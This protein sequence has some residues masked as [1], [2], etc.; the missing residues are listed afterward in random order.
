VTFGS[1]SKR[2]RGTFKARVA[3]FWRW[4][5]DVAK[6]FEA[7]AE[8]DDP[9]EVVNEVGEYMERTLPGLSWALGRGEN[10]KHS[11]TVTGEG[12]VPKQLLAAYWQSQAVELPGWTFYASR[13]PSPPET[14]KDL[15]IG[16]SEDDQVDA[17]SV[18]VKTSVDEEAEQI[19]IIAWH[20]SLAKVPAEHHFQI[21]FLLLDEALG[22]FGVQTWLGEI[23]VEPIEDST[24]TRSL[25]DLPK[26]I[27]QATSYHG[28]EK[29]PPL[30]TLS[31][32]EVSEEVSG[33][34]GDTVVG[35]SII[36][37]V[38]FDYIENDGTSTEDPLEDTG[39]ELVYVAI[40]GSAFDEGSEVEAL[41]AIE[42]ELDE[43]LLDADSGQTLG[44]ATG[45][46]QSYIDVLI[47]DGDKSRQLI[48]Q[49][50]DRLQLSS[51][52]RLINFN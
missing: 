45:S 17:A 23:K 33:P 48:E 38:I 40:E 51:R 13:Q 37:D 32:Y 39:A 26:F 3:E 46:K 25:I 42:E 28:W 4:F 49:T 29:F 1:K 34:R 24:G 2:F 5:P 36:P 12:L 19:D 35:S 22:E 16:V 9:Q 50:L 15:A 30:E 41:N 27:E 7:A 14:L 52:C 18:I 21:L 44:G 43:A 10:G 31:T 6:R 8:A 11:F 47:L 20:P